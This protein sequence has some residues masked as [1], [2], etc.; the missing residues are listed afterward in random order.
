MFVA[1]LFSF[2]KCMIE[3]WRATLGIGRVG[4]PYSLTNPTQYDLFT[5]DKNNLMAFLLHLNNV[6]TAGEQIEF[7]R[8]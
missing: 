5:T 7:S 8:D 6:G 4:M 2:V 3:R 1:P